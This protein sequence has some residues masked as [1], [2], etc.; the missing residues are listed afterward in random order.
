MKN[1]KDFQAFRE[2]AL[3]RLYGKNRMTNQN[4]PR[5]Q[6]FAR[7]TRRYIEKMA[8]AMIPAK[9]HSNAAI[10]YYE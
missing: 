2:R 7:I 9:S 8:A 3:R 5:V 10:E 6:A 4:D 1:I